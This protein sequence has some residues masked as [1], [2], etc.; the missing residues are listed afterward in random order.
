MNTAQGPNPAKSLSLMRVA[1]GLVIAGLVVA[2]L[3]VMFLGSR[4]EPVR[5]P[6]CLSNTKQLG[7]AIAMYAELYHDRC[8]VDS[9]TNPTLVGSMKLLAATAGSTKIL[10]CPS[11]K[12][13][14]V[15]PARDFASLTVSNISYS[16][17][18]GFVW[19]DVTPDSIVALDRIY[20]YEKGAAWPS[21]SNHGAKGG[22]ILYL[23]GHCD[24]QTKLPT[25]LKDPRGR[26]IV[27]SP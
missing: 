15:K 21:N 1:S 5:R 4:R 9:A 24:F 7:L 27:L 26:S 3:Q 20:T 8:P 23:D 10:I 2:I 13:R 18:P 12:R 19:G 16:Y 22:N 17:V 11:D 14:G 25:V 6:N